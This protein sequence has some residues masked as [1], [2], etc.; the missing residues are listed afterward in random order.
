M[1]KECGKWKSAFDAKLK[2]QKMHCAVDPKCDPTVSPDG[3]GK[4]LNEEWKRHPWT[5]FSQTFQKPLG[6][7]FLQTHMSDQNAREA[8]VKNEHT[9]EKLPSK[10]R[11][12]DEHLSKLQALSLNAQTR[13]RLEQVLDWFNNHAHPQCQ[14]NCLTVTLSK[15]HSSH[16]RHLME[17]SPTLSLI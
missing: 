12:A 10:M 4:A 15:Q 16:H 14:S 9:Q 5:A 17:T 8:F 1:D 13:T 7:I 6:G 2:H 3:C 11:G